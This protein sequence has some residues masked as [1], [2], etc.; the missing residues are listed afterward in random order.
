MT[1]AQAGVALVQQRVAVARLQQRP[2][3]ENR[4]FLEL[5]E[6]SAR[7]WYDMAQTM[8][9]LS[10]DYLDMATSVAWLMQRAY[11]AETARDLHKIRLDY[12]NAGAGTVLGADVLLRDID[13]FTVDYL[14][15]TRSKKAPIKVSFSI[16]Q[17]W[18]TALKQLRADGVACLETT[19]EQLDRLYPGFYLHKVRN[20]EVQPVGLSSGEGIRGTLR[21]IGVSTFRGADG[22]VQQLVYPPDVMPLS[23]YDART[24][25]I[26]LRADPQQ[27]RLFENNGAATMWRLELPPGIND[28][29]L[30]GILDAYLVLSFDAFFDGDL[31][32]SV[33]AGLPTTGSASRVTSM[34]L[35]APD[36]LFFLRTQGTGVLAVD[37]ADLPRTQIDLARTSFVLNLVGD[38]TVVANRAVTLTP[39]STGVALD[40]TTTPSASCRVPRWP[41][42]SALP[43]RT[44]SPSPSRVRPPGSWTCLCTK[45]TRSPGGDGLSDLATSEQAL[46]PPSGTGNAP[47]SARRSRSTSTPG[48]RPTRCRSRCRRASRGRS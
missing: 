6:F 13:F 31:E 5:R 29:D 2:T 39:A 25:A 11:V 34:R 45:P 8:K 12:R 27:L 32:T 21:N 38:P 37:A 17:N 18:P 10:T 1:Q 9:G 36:E 22:T 28:V 43:S 3:E 40:L 44:R 41:R 4:E 20:V 46:R 14:T 26:V 42:C 35:Q 15:S 47:G 33:K 19:L 16:S 23:Q 48:R 30:G 7:H 24:D